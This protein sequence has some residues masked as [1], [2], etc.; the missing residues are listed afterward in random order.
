LP[1]FSPADGKMMRTY[2]TFTVLNTY[3]LGMRLHRWAYS[4]TV[5]A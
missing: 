1:L 5:T 2:R 3:P 4:L